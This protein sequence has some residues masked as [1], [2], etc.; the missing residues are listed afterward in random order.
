MLTRFLAV[1]VIAFSQFSCDSPRR[2]RSPRAI[3]IVD[4]SVEVDGIRYA[5]KAVINPAAERGGPALLF[6]HGAGECGTHGLKMLTVGLPKHA[7]DDPEMWPYVLI[8][9]QKPTVDSEWEDYEDA[10]LAMIGDA[11]HLGLIDLDR[12]GI[13]GLSQG[14]HGTVALA[15]R[16]PELF[17]AAA[18]VCA[19]I[20]R[21][22]DED[23]VFMDWRGV[24]ASSPVVVD[25][26]QRM[27]SMPVWIHHGDADSVVPVGESRALHTALERLGADVRYTEYESVDHNSWDDAYTDGA[28]AAWFKDALGG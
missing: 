4:L 3:E 21:A 15:S 2:D 18:P 27:S 23:G 17:V 19:Y 26:A 12:L 9:P 25:A 1:A 14:G 10:V 7:V 16:H 13:T 5:G 20:G 8:V 22:W 28:F 6:L 11:A 24:D